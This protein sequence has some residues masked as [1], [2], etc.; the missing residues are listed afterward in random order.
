MRETGQIKIIKIKVIRITA[1][2]QLGIILKKLILVFIST[3]KT[4]EDTLDLIMK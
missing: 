2:I 3:E 4:E 1:I